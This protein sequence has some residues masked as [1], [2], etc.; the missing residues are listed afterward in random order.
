MK[1]RKIMRLVAFIMTLCL[2]WTTCLPGVRAASYVASNT[3]TFIGDGGSYDIYTILSQYQFFVAEDSNAPVHTVGGVAVG[4]KATMAWFG[5]GALAPSYI[6]EMNTV[7]GFEGSWVG[8]K[9]CPILYYGA[10]PNG[11]IIEGTLQQNPGYMNM[12][13]AFGDLQTESTALAK[14]SKSLTAENGVVTIDCTGNEDVYVSFVYNENVKIKL[15]LND[16]VGLDWF[17]YHIC[18]VSITGVGKDVEAQLDF[19]NSITLDGAGEN[20]G[21]MGQKLKKMTDSKGNSQSNGGEQL[22]PGGTNLV[23]N[24]PDAESVNSYELSGQLVAPNAKVKLGGS[25]EGGVVAKNLEY[26]NGEAHFYPMSNALKTTGTTDPGTT[27]PTDPEKPGTDPTDP[28]KPGTDPTNPGTG[29]TTPG[30]NPGTTDPGTTNPEGG[31]GTTDPGTTTPGASTDTPSTATGDLDI[32]VQDEKTGDPVPNAKVE[33]VYPSGRRDTAT[34][35]ENGKITKKGLEPGDYTVTV[36]EVPDGYTVTTGK[37]DKVTVVAGETKQHV[38][39]I[40]S[41]GAANAEKEDDEDDE[42]DTDDGG[43]AEAASKN[44]AK[45]GD[46]FPIAVPVV[47]LIGAATT[48]FILG[49]KKRYE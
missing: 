11:C 47:L 35:D 1:K 36:T 45:T 30:G 9:H 42:D 16:K 13:Q 15:V 22:N 49:Y 2:V 27:D 23:W 41:E 25:V 19:T 31:T 43:E 7:N 10:N 28:E 18:C 24:F 5:H 29:T 33:I 40:N 44:A 17:K 32:V 21:S 34:T 38:V 6:G 26:L 37:Q 8:D 46:A 14:S 12:T 3:A 48:M 4:K 39:K 20:N